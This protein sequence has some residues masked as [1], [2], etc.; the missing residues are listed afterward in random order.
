MATVTYT[1]TTITTANRE[2]DPFAISHAEWV[3]MVTTQRYDE[4]ALIAHGA[5]ATLA[6]VV[7]PKMA[8]DIKAAAETAIADIWQWADE[9]DLEFRLAAMVRDKGDTVVLALCDEYLAMYR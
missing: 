5:K 3:A 4:L 6:H 9:A 2:I 1:T 8:D 7:S